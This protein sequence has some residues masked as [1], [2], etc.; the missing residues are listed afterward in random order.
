MGSIRGQRGVG[1]GSGWGRPGASGRG[2]GTGLGSTW[3]RCN[4]ERVVRTVGGLQRV[5]LRMVVLGFRFTEFRTA[6]C[7]FAQKLPKPSAT[8]SS[9]LVPMQDRIAHCILLFH[10][11]CGRTPPS[12]S[13]PPPA[14]RDGRAAPGT[15]HRRGFRRAK[16]TR[17]TEGA[18]TGIPRQGLPPWQI[19][20]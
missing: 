2:I 17:A 7:V 3:G 11:T 12:V 18:G 15:G 8:P 10:N 6:A 4:R 19:P 14:L 1:S 20:S 16:T 9:H 5:V 13:P